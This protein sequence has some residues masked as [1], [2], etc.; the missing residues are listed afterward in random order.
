MGV[1][2]KSLQCCR[3]ILA[4]SI[5]LYYF[6]KTKTKKRLKVTSRV[7]KDQLQMY[8][9]YFKIN[10]MCTEK[11]VQKDFIGERDTDLLKSSYGD[12]RF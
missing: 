3:M 4:P 2:S 11:C 9:W 10:K 5:F 6:V 7:N 12:F 8:K 1:K